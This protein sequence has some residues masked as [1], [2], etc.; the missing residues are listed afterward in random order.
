M[1]HW[2]KEPLLH[3]V[4][5]GGLLFAVYGWL[6]HEASPEPGVVRITE[7]DVN[8]LKEMWTRQRQ[9]PP[10]EREL[11]GL[12]ADYLKEALLAR[13]A[14]DL[15]LEENDTVVRRRLAQKMEFLLQDT[16]R[17]AEPGEAELHSFYET[18]RSRYQTSK[19][20]SFSQI[21]F[22]SEADRKSVV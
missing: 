14:R 10:E 9:R 18:N 20:I 17:L 16:A 4:I 7:A 12:V 22:K 8:W 15:G 5:L 19:K 1:R 6:N 13:E 21:Y 11:R 3:F 2:Y